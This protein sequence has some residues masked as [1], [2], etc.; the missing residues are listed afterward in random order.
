MKTAFV[1]LALPL[2]L[3]SPPNQGQQTILVTGRVTDSTSNAGIQAANVRVTEL[4]VSVGTDMAGRYRIV[5]PERHHGSDIVVQVR[6]IGFR[7]QQKLVK[8]SA[9]SVTADFALV[10]DVNKLHEVLVTGVSD[11]TETKK[12]GFSV[13]Q[14]YGSTAANPAFAAA[15]SPMPPS[16]NLPGRYRPVDNTESYD[17][18]V[19]NPFL[20][21]RDNSLST[22][23][24]DVDRASY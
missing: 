8:L 6:A 13:S 16:Q 19:D 5:L 17:R 15:A 9:D 24:V 20:G 14:V 18:I 10:V 22:F 4:G 11:A 21:A 12:L 23:S 7:P 1:S 3:L 2:L